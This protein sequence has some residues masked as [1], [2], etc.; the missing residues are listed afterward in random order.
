MAGEKE[1]MN[2][3]LEQWLAVIGVLI[4]L[5]TG[6]AAW[7]GL[8]FSLYNYWQSRPRRRVEVVFA[9]H[10]EVKG[11]LIGVI[12]INERGPE[13]VIEGVGFEYADGSKI[14]KFEQPL[15]PPLPTEVPPGHRS[16]YYYELEELRFYVQER[17]AIPA[18][19][20]CRDAT[21]RYHRSA[22]LSREIR[23]ALSP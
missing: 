1:K 11:K 12:F 17:K 14:E 10:P 6:G 2:L 16:I 5:L 15:G 23:S 9:R 18:S 19:A 4:G 20:Y 21:G 7:V 13:V 8:G 3:T 22:K